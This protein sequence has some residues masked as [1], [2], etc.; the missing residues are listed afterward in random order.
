MRRQAKDLLVPLFITL[1]ILIVLEIISTALLPAFGAHKYIIPFNILIVLYLGFKLETPYLALLILVVQ[2]FHSFFSIEGWE[3]GTIAGIFICIVISY[4]RDV[5]HF[6]SAVI[7]M[8]VTQLFQVV[9]FVIVAALFYLKTNNIDFLV[10]KMW[11]F[12]PES[13]AISLMAP[14]FFSIFDRIWGAGGDGMLGED[15]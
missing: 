7:T 14:F 2:Y 5:L 15:V 4:L 9:W 6:S 12:I 1:L 13:I 10:E 11:R 8:A 3:L